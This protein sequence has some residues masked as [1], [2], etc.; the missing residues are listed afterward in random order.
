MSSDKTD[1]TSNLN[2]NQI[3]IMIMGNLSSPPTKLTLDLLNAPQIKQSSTL[4]QVPYFTKEIK[5]PY[6]V[7]YNIASMEN[8]YSK[9]VRFFFDKIKFRQVLKKYSKHASNNQAQYD[10]NI[11]YNIKLMIKLLFPTEWP[12]KYNYTTSYDQFILKKGPELSWKPQ[13]NRFKY[14][15]I[16]SDFTYITLNGNKYTIIKAIWLND[17]YNK[18]DY[19]QLVEEYNKYSL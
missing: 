10:D 18:P 9:I 15:D 8:G 5:Y 12:S 17:L 19:F 14:A 6:D 1:I 2:E 11:K 13:I 16:K 7:L 3:N 4:S